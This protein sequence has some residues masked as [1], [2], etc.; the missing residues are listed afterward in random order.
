M[1][2]DDAYRLIRACSSSLDDAAALLQSEPRL[3]LERTGLGET[4]LHYLAVEDQVEA[5]RFLHEHG[6]DLNVLNDFGDSPIT[7]ALALGN[8]RT[9]AFL[10]DHGADVRVSDGAGRSTLHA[11]VVGGDRELAQRILAVGVPVTVRDNMTHEVFDYGRYSLRLNGELLAGAPDRVRLYGD[12]PSKGDRR[13]LADRDVLQ[14]GQY[15][16]EY[17]AHLDHKR[18]AAG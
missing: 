3:L 18:R 9:A 1:G 6:A 10:L 4:P 16:I 13:P 11:A 15:L 2:R 14:I 7:E 8:K 12:R 5:V 17:I